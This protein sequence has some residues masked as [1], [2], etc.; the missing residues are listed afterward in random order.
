MAAQS[1]GDVPI[2]DQASCSPQ[3][4]FALS[5]R[6]SPASCG[7]LPRHRNTMHPLLRG[8]CR[9]ATRVARKRNTVLAPAQH[10]DPLQR[11]VRQVV[12]DS[13]CTPG[14]RGPRIG[15]CGS[16]PSEN[17]P[18]LRGQAFQRGRSRESSLQEGESARGAARASFTGIRCP[19]DR[20][21][22]VLALIFQRVSSG[23]HVIGVPAEDFDGLA[24]VPS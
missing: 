11:L 7:L 8:K 19:R 15:P 21:R 3:P 1:P 17:G 16:D 4:R 24:I 23:S 13:G 12:S 10:S 22:P 5:W 18:G 20:D 9:A 6:V 14:T 2:S